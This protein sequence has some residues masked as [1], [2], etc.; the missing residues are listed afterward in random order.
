MSRV[1]IGSGF[2][3][4]QVATIMAYGCIL[5]PETLAR[6]TNGVSYEDIPRITDWY[7]HEETLRAAL[8]DIVNAM[9]ALDFVLD[10]LTDPQLRRRV[11]RG[12][13]KGEQLH[14]LA[15]QVHYGK[16]GQTDG[17]DLQQQMSRA[18]C[19]VLIL[20]AIIYW[21]ILEIDRVLRH[22]DPAEEG[23]DPSLLT[24][25]SPIG[26]DNVVLYSEYHL[27]RRLVRHP[28]AVTQLPGE[29]KP[30]RAGVY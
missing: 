10:Y 20:A 16:Q 9:L 14:G 4:T 3:D 2:R 22:C 29:T 1:A 25:I 30:S 13:L 19:L 28:R 24:H 11:W 5:G 17:R 15:R 18:S 23:V 7:L 12:L 8:A 26:W 6:L 21:Q 27:D